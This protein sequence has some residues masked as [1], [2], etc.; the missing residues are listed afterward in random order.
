MSFI[1]SIGSLMAEGGLYEL[2]NSTFADV[3]KMITG[4]KVPQNMRALRIVAEELL[5]PVLTGGTVNDL[6]GREKI[7][8]DIS[9]RSKTSYL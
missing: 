6:H 1:G 8:P 3:Q 9:S 7:L 4:K 5:R 2:L